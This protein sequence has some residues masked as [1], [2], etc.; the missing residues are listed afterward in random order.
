MNEINNR[1]F[2]K[3]GARIREKQFHQIKPR[4]HA[5]DMRPNRLVQSSSLSFQEKKFL[6][7]KKTGAA[8]VFAHPAYPL[9][10]KP[11]LRSHN[12]TCGV[13]GH[14]QADRDENETIV[15]RRG[16]YRSLDPKFEPFDVCS[17]CMKGDYDPWLE[18]RDD[19]YRGT[20]FSLFGFKRIGSVL[21][22]ADWPLYSDQERLIQVIDDCID[23]DVITPTGGEMC[24]ISFSID[25]LTVGNDMYFNIPKRRPHK[26]NVGVHYS[27]QDIYTVTFID[28]NPNFYVLLL[29]QQEDTMVCTF[30]KVFTAE[31]GV[32]FVQTFE[33]WLEHIYTEAVLLSLDDN[34]AAGVEGRDTVETQMQQQLQ[35]Q[36]M[37]KAEKAKS[38]HTQAEIARRHSNVQMDKRMHMQMEE[39]TAAENH[40]GEHEP[41]FRKRLSV[42]AFFGDHQQ[43]PPMS[44]TDPQLRRRS[45]AMFGDMKRKTPSSQLLS[46]LPPTIPD[47]P[48]FGDSNNPSSPHF[49]Y[50]RPVSRVSVESTNYNNEYGFEKDDEEEDDNEDDNDEGEHKFEERKSPIAPSEKDPASNAG[51]IRRKS[52]VTKATVASYMQ[53]LNNVFTKAELT[54]FSRIVRTYKASGDF[55]DFTR[56]LLH[57]YNRS[58]FH[59]LPG[60]RLFLSAADQPNFDTFLREHNIDVLPMYT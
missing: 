34:I 50:S 51:V 8:V 7:K 47:S 20:P 14:V 58:R 2:Q 9:F 32:K 33:T 46:S 56:Q 57:L 45:I 44:P 28:D 53:T 19:F 21:T 35:E 31:I 15:A 29:T 24:E 12:W 1:H 5:I 10:V 23:N 17:E 25:G 38:R 22:G 11:E 16:H 48:V 26:A 6:D 18:H 30:F 40:M 59:L 13:C 52:R 49:D 42:V 55:L 37:R 41:F 60:L 36:A 39:E 43:S 54:E 27:V 4:S 3:G